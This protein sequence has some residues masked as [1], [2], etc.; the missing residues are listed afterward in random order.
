MSDTSIVS[1]IVPVY[2]QEKYLDA[3]FG[4]LVTQTYPHLELVFV[5]DGSTDASLQMIQGYAQQDSRVR[6][7]DKPN[8]GLVDAT[9]AGLS[10][11]T[12]DFVCFLDP[13][14]VYGPD[15][16][17]YFLSFMQEDCDFV[18]AG[19]YTDK[20][21][22]QT[23][24]YLDKDRI[25]TQEELRQSANI[26][27]HEA[28]SSKMSNRFFVSRCSKI[29]RK[30]VIQKITA[31]FQNYR[32]LTLGEDT[33]FTYLLLQCS[34][35]G[36]TVRQPNTYYYNIS[37]GN[38][39]MKSTAI[40]SYL[41]KANAAYEALLALTKKYNT[42]PNQAYALYGLLVDG[43]VG[44]TKTVPQQKLAQKLLFNPLYYKGFRLLCKKHVFAK[45]LLKAI[46]PM[47]LVYSVKDMLKRH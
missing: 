44:R 12:G 39:M 26:F 40:D 38:S 43:L 14:D 18:A 36:R 20:D 16:I 35:G 27:L 15:H 21:G 10:A 4:C 2:N 24:I 7:V 1:V 3:A 47:Q 46:L 31:E 45:T 23:P 34:R 25:Y 37:N 8:G 29:Y 6:I 32:H 19:I 22:V 42:D 41:N 28:G 9:L 5:N 11:A 33:I 17:R 30:E 13:D